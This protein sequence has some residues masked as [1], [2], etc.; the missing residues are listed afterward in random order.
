MSTI[1]V[2]APSIQA[3]DVRPRLKIR[4]G[5]RHSQQ[6]ASPRKGS[7]PPMLKR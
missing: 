7:S 2:Q 6:A 4:K 5:K 1:D 3:S